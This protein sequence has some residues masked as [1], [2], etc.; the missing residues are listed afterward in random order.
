VDN[1]QMAAVVAG[2]ELQGKAT[3]VAMAASIQK[4][5]FMEVA[6]AEVQGL[7]VIMAVIV[8]AQ[9]DQ[10]RLLQLQAQR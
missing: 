5:N 6:V 9:A 8:A 10:D 2:L 3:M 1:N 4:V 7:V